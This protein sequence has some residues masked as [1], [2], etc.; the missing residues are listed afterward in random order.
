MKRMTEYFT[1]LI[2]I[3][4]CYYVVVRRT[5][6]R[7]TLLLLT[8]GLG[9]GASVGPPREEDGAFAVAA[10][11]LLTTTR[12]A[13]IGTCLTVYALFA[14]L[15][16]VTAP[17]GL[18]ASPSNALS[19]GVVGLHHGLVAELD[20]GFTAVPCTLIDV[21]IVAIA[22]CYARD[23]VRTLKK[24]GQ[25]VASA[26]ILA[27]LLVIVLRTVV[28]ILCALLTMLAHFILH[29][30]PRATLPPFTAEGDRMYE[31]HHPSWVAQL[32]AP[33]RRWWVMAL[34]RLSEPIL[35][36][37]ICSLPLIGIDG[38]CQC[39]AVAGRRK[40]AAGTGAYSQVRPRPSGA[41]ERALDG[42]LELAEI[43]SDAEVEAKS[44]AEA[45]AVEIDRPSSDVSEEGMETPRSA[46]SDSSGGLGLWEKIDVALP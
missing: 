32:L 46:M 18:G 24:R 40:A 45:D 27:L 12:A 28:F 3:L 22:T 29:R 10:L 4:M 30:R 41:A 11:P 7:A 23:L 15:L 25:S 35:F 16:E 31:R 8:T 17:R 43:H 33:Q 36:V 44:D 13:V 6:L 34:W 9:L 37:T 21:A 20:V 14:A 38:C 26:S 5:A 19:R 42:E 1:N 2:Y 39:P